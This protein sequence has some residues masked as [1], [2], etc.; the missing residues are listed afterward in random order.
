MFREFL[1]KESETKMSIKVERDKVAL[2]LDEWKKEDA[3]GKIEGQ[4]SNK[5]KCNLP[6]IEK[7]ECA[8]LELTSQKFCIRPKRFFLEEAT[9]GT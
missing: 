9:R 8:N 1:E 5:K 2:M 4:Q 3:A 6:A 7:A